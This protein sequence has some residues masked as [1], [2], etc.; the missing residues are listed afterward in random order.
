M[1]DKDTNPF[2]ELFQGFGKSLSLPGPDINDLL[3]YHRKNLQALQAA[4]QIGSQSAQAL[5]SKQRDVLEQS[6]AEISDAVQEVRQGDPQAM[7]GSSLDL[8]RKAFDAT[9][10]NATDMAEIL[11]QGNKDAFEVLKD[12]V[13]ESVE[14]LSGK[15]STKS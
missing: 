15:T 6:L 11:V 14:D 3:D 9:V 13:I 10:Q 5:M 7:A 4:T 12:R 2:T 8:A 1:A